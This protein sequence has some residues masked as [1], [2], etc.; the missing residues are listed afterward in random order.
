MMRVN[1][2]TL[3]FRC[4]YNKRERERKIKKKNER[5]SRKKKCFDVLVSIHDDS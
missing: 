2:I 1:V 3:T 5:K 4:H